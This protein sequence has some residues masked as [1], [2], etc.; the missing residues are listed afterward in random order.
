MIVQLN[1]DGRMKIDWKYHNSSSE[2]ILDLHCVSEEKDAP[3]TF[4]FMFHF[5]FYR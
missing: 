4:T 1:K 3:V 2:N 5:T